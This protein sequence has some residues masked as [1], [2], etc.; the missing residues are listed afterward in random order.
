VVF[1]W[2]PD[3]AK[4]EETMDEMDRIEMEIRW[5]RMSPRERAVLRQSHPELREFLDE[6]QRQSDLG[7]LWRTRVCLLAIAVIGLLA[8]GYA[9]S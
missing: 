8:M 3:Q 1:A 2:F 9:V 6:L 4:E 7:R 5:Y